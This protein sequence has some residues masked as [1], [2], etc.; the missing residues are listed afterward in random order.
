MKYKYEQGQIL[1]FNNGKVKGIGK[2]SGYMSKECWIIEILQIVGVNKEDYP[3][4]H[5]VVAESCLANG[6]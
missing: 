3:F 6:E 5:I 4:S 2:V 1:Q